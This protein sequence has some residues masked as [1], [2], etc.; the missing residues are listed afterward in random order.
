MT[1]TL[2]PVEKTSLDDQVAQW[3]SPELIEAIGRITLEEWQELAIS[4]HAFRLFTTEKE[5]ILSIHLRVPKNRKNV[6][7]LV[8]LASV[9]GS[10]FWYGVNFIPQHWPAIQQFVASIFPGS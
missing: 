7:M 1:K 2:P 10:M 5:I 6:T 9:I 3:L 4:K 8:V